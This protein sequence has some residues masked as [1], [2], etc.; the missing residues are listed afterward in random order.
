MRLVVH[1]TPKASQNK[2]EGWA[3]DVDGSKIL[4]AKVTAV[5]EGGK[6]N[7]ALI[8]LLSKMLHIPKSSISLIRGETSRVKHFEIEIDEEDA[9]V[10]FNVIYQG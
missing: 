8:K 10:C 9:E 1:L 7:A 4:R 3:L 6:A 2:I 5:P